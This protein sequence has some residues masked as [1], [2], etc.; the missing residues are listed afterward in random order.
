MSMST[1]GQVPAESPGLGVR[2]VDDLLAALP[3]EAAANV[4][5]AKEIGGT[6]FIACRPP[7]EIEKD[8][9]LNLEAEQYKVLLLAAK[10]LKYQ[11]I[12][13]DL[14]EG[15]TFGLVASRLH[16]VYIDLMVDDKAGASA[17]IPIDEKRLRIV[18]PCGENIGRLDRRQ[19]LT[20]TQATVFEQLANGATIQE[21]ADWRRTGTQDIL[22]LCNRMGRRLGIDAGIGGQRTIEV[23]RMAVAMKNLETYVTIIAGALHEFQ[24]KVLA[25]LRWAQLRSEA[26][27]LDLDSQ[28]VGAINN[29]EI[30]SRLETG[31]YIEP[32]TAK[33]G[34]LD[35]AG[36]VAA[37]LIK[38]AKNE[39]IMEDDLTQPMAR[40]VI[41]REAEY[42]MKQRQNR[43]AR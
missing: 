14:G 7:S 29:R 18:P 25:S 8:A 40:E 17:Y 11:A 9:L 36:L 12:A 13:D 4:T 23:R 2:M 6:L 37:M 5:L 21:I 1:G 20:R 22:S 28:I 24:P 32:G 10:G 43:A 33:H 35:L 27:E 39:V 34:R 31:G 19:T 16:S 41:R 42:F 3:Q 30:L 15:A 38:E 26:G